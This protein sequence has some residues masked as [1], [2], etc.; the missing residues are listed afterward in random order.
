LKKEI[1]MAKIKAIHA[2]EI[3]DSRGIPTIE[4]TM[5]ADDGRGVVSSIPSGASTGRFEAVELRDKDLNRFNGQGVLK[6]VANVNEIIAKNIIG[7][8]PTKQNQI[9]QILINLDGTA[10]KSKLGAN[11]IL[12]VSMSACELGAVVSSLQTYEYLSQKYSLVKLSKERLPTPIFN[13]INGG[14]HGAGNLD[15]QEFHLIPSSQLPVTKCIEIGDTIYQNLKSLLIKKKAIHSV[16]DEGGFAPNLFSNVDALELL[17]EAIQTSNFKFNQD[18][19]L[20]LDIAANSFYRGGKYQIRDRAEAYSAEEFV[21]Y[22]IDLKKQ[23]NLL[24]IEDPIQEDDWSQWTAINTEL[25]QDTMIVGDDL[26]VT[27]KKRLE[28]AIAQKSCN[29]VLVKPNQI[30]TITETVQFVKLA[31]ANKLNVIV[32]HRS[33]DTDED[34]IADFAVGIGANYAKFGAPGRMERVAKY[35]RLAFIYDYLATSQ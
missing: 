19:F 32:S 15:F 35:N 27:N 21:S 18:V 20:G 14:R 25:G 26:L 34:F 5:W 30:G 7:L 1:F 33:G 29:S 16:G 17:S 11:A 23:Y 6:A 24:S 4:T 13:L 8:D 31:K 9:D 22:L 10:N 28:Q 12:S 2:R 3:L